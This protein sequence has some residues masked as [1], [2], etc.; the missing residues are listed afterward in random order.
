M[1]VRKNTCDI[2][3]SGEETRKTG[4]PR[5]VLMI[6]PFPVFACFS[7]NIVKWSSQGMLRL[8]QEAMNEL[9]QPTVTNIIKHIGMRNR[10]RF[11]GW[12][13]LSWMRKRELWDSLGFFW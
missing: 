10:P 13:R 6:V 9:F 1:E 11:D 2:T 8:T 3:M 12:F 4:Q 7:I 5:A